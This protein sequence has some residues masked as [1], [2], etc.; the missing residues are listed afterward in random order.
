MTYSRDEE[1]S[2]R[3]L[4]GV[5]S[6]REVSEYLERHGWTLTEKDAVREVWF[7]VRDGDEVA[8]VMLPFWSEV[9][10][11]VKRLSE[12]LMTVAFVEMWSVKTTVLIDAPKD[13][14]KD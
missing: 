12:C 3:A 14:F 4:A 11:Y 13:L 6:P 8:S 2:F 7:L 9:R 5:V 1:K 10:D